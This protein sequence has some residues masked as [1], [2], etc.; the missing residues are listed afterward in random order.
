MKIYL[1]ALF[2]LL[3]ACNEGKSKTSDPET[4]KKVQSKIGI[5]KE[6]PVKTPEKL[7]SESFTDSSNIGIKGRNKITI[8]K[9]TDFDSIYVEIN[10]F[11]RDKQHWMLRQKM[12]FE[13]D[14]IIDCDPQIIDFNNDGFKD[15]TYQ[16]AVAARGANELRTL[17]IFD[18]ES[19]LL[20]RIV[21][22]DNYPNLEYNK[23]LNCIT[24]W[25]VYGGTTTSFLKVQ[26]DSLIEFANVDV[27]DGYIE[28]YEVKNGQTKRLIR[29]K[30]EDDD[31]YIRYKNYKPLKEE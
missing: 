4:H 15:I 27:F 31:I 19:G 7:I 10:F 13:M 18:K 2:I 12:N 5:L 28:S 14:A 9:I 29:K 6:I 26:K 25:A 23:E 8:Q 24:G 20:R 17:F 30:M 21:N 22:S 16:S 11:K 3:I 1:T